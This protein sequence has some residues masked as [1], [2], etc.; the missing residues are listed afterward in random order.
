M[1]LNRALVFTVS[2]VH[3]CYWPKVSKCVDSLPFSLLNGSK[4]KKKPTGKIFCP[5]RVTDNVSHLFFVHLEGCGTLK[6]MYNSRHLLHFQL[7]SLAWC[8]FT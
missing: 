5:Y 1:D 2:R 6:R 4:K 3:L 8:Y 7:S